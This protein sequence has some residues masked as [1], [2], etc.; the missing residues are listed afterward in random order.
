MITLKA[1][2][3]IGEGISCKVETGKAIVEAGLHPATGGDGLAARPDDFELIP[4]PKVLLER[5]AVPGLLGSGNLGDIDPQIQR[6]FEMDLAQFVPGAPAASRDAAFRCVRTLAEAIDRGDA[7]AARALCASGFVDPDGRSAD[8]MLARLQELFDRTASR[9]FS[10][11]GIEEV[12]GS[13]TE[14]VAR[15]RASW[16]ASLADGDGP[17]ASEIVILDVVVNRTDDGAWTITGLR[18]R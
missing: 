10:V 17:D 7:D 12:H 5:L 11:L 3:K 6:V 2:G 13:D 18:S 8:E 16:Q 14:I 4:I 1:R 9:R 15:V